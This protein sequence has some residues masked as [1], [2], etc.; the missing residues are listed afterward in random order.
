MHVLKI[1]VTFQI[2]ECLI[3]P[4]NLMQ[5]FIVLILLRVEFSNYEAPDFVFCYISLQIH[6]SKV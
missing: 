5:F 3:F 1:C 4:F 2:H 6:V